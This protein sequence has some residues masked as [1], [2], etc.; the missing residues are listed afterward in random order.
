MFPIFPGF[1]HKAALPWRCYDKN[2][3]KLIFR[4]NSPENAKSA[5]FIYGDP[6]DW[7]DSGN[8][9]QAWYYTETAM[10]R[11]RSAGSRVTWKV[12]IDPPEWKRLRYCFRMKT[13]N[14][15]WLLF[16]NGV[17]KYSKKTISHPLNQFFHY[18]YIHAIDS[19]QAPE[20][21]QKT[22]W[23]Q[24]FPERFCRNKGA[25]VVIPEKIEDWEKGKPEFRNFFGGNLAGIREKLPWLANLGIN[26]LYLTP[27]YT[28]PSNHK[29]NI[30]DY[31]AIDPHFGDLN[32]MKTLVKEAHALNIKVMLDAVFNHAG[33]THPFWQDVLKN[34]EK[35]SYADYFHVRRFPI[36]A[37]Q[38]P[39]NMDYEAFAWQ[40]RMPKWNTENPSV[41]KYLLESAAYWI[42]E[43]DID[44][45][46]LDVA[47][48]ISFDFLRDFTKLVRSIKKNFYILGEMWHDAHEWLQPG[49]FDAAMNYPLGFAVS[50]CF[51]QKEITPQVFTQKLFS[52]LDRYS[53]P[54]NSIAF[55]LL[56]S[57]DTE[58]AL[59][60]A[61]GDK[62]ALKN[63]FT[64]LFLMP[65]A[66]SVYYGTEIG[67]EG[68]NDP[69]CRRPM[70]WN[71]EKQDKNLLLFFQNLINFRKKYLSIIKDAIIT[72]F[73]KN[74]VHYWEF[75]PAPVGNVYGGENSGGRKKTPTKPPLLTVVY[76]GAKK[77]SGFKIPGKCVFGAETDLSRYESGNLPARI[78]AVYERT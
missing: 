24:I 60:R 28:S 70:I 69:D 54:H 76:T 1:E 34:Q 17:E 55:N 31:F 32:E 73:E 49:L 6:Y 12:E 74:G 25:D 57:H 8:N 58:R 9:T 51:L 15:E 61:G 44:A 38:K 68:K 33:E 30:E 14:G 40:K 72:Y 52:V 64:M 29:Y 13:S 66:P 26:G 41:R 20:W 42:R 63:A 35:S 11:Q 46:R 50:N 21:V 27:V 56:D 65:G 7:R 16:E 22:V 36:R 43:C 62:Q 5:V 77:V 2:R 75:S 47:N 67:M 18:P 48:E 3:D 71:E 78:V 10:Y 19:L 53:D 4:L 59:T 39:R 45:W 37:E 23:Y